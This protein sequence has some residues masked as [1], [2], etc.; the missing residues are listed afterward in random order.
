M[1]NKRQDKPSHVEYLKCR[2]IK[3]NKQWMQDFIDTF[4]GMVV[5]D[6]KLDPNCTPVY[7][8]MKKDQLFKVA[9]NRVNAEF[10][11]E[12]REYSYDSFL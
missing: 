10:I 3:E 5:E 12:F 7:D 11:S 2:M 9:G 8:L 4:K 6:P 1:T